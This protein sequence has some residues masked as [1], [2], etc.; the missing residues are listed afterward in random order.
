MSSA[1]HSAISFSFSTVFIPHFFE[2]NE[3]RNK[4]LTD[5][6]D[7]SG[8]GLGTEMECLGSNEDLI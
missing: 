4:P 5:D 7:L 3:K 6:D 2:V 8:Q 1:I